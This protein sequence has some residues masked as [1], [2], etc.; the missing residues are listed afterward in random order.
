MKKLNQLLKVPLAVLITLFAGISALSAQ[1]R[2]LEG[3]RESALETTRRIADKVIRETRFEYE[4]V[5]MTF[6]AG[7]IRFTLE[8]DAT[9]ETE[10][11]TYA[12]A[13]L[14]ADE[15]TDGFAGL[16][17]SGE[18]VL[19][20]NGRE[21]FR[22]SS[23]HLELQEYTYNRYRFAEKIP[24]KW[25]KGENTLL[26]KCATGKHVSTVVV[27]PVNETDEKLLQVNALPATA[28]TPDIHWLINGPWK[29]S[30]ES[31]S[32]ETKNGM[33]QRFP[34]EEG[35][36]DYYTAGKRAMA[37][38]MEEPPLLRQLVIPGNASYT[39]DP[40]ADWNYANGG[41][42]LA[43]LS[44]Y[45]VSGD[46]KYL[47][48]VKTFADNILENEDYF[49][50]QYFNLQA[51]RGSY[52][53][54]S[55]MT[56][57]DDSGGPVLPFAELQRID[58]GSK[59]YLPLLERNVD[60]VM[61]KQE[62]LEDLTFSR[63]EPRPATVWADDLFMSVPFLLRMAEI[64]GDKGLY[65]EV[66]R[67]VIQFNQY[68]CDSGT[69]LYF[70]GWYNQQKENTPVRWGRANGWIAWA[71]SEALLYM[72]KKHPSYKKIL[73]IY[74]SHMEAIAS[75]QDSSGMW[76]Q[77]PDHPE[78]FEESSCTA[79]FTLAMARGARMGWLKKEYGGKALKGWNALQDK[80]NEDGTVVD[81]CR[82]TEIGDDV[83]F[84]AGRKRFDHDP[85]GLGAMITAGCEISLLNESGVFRGSN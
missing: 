42:M 50:W 47:D 27:L 67:Q 71:T 85:R 26:V 19:F 51:V 6:N 9:G 84:Y 61:N 62:R 52:H 8:K 78:T 43:I 22:G 20:V 1:E 56:M 10:G 33:E 17:F 80:I 81:I 72:P 40:Y 32:A 7:I 70:H 34:P 41:T 60:Y 58:P 68:L 15:D 76:H 74:R 53:R 31:W 39:R 38:Q 11:V 36:R 37:W 48:F 44:L 75:M 23:D 35:F 30:P 29:P 16:A 82:G 55:R 73:K 18:I 3:A 57:L 24:V 45:Q 46:D 12:R 69:G 79:M 63:P 21:L 64:T 54:I 4:M 59:H 13:V 66:A 5:P 65:D 28:E 83:A 49:R 14:Q 25:L 2:A 77:V